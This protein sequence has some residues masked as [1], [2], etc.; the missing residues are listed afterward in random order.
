MTLRTPVPFRV[1]AL[2][3]IAVSVFAAHP[4]RDLRRNAQRPGALA[5]AVQGGRARPAARRSESTLRQRL[6]SLSRRRRERTDRAL[7]GLRMVSRGFR[8]RVGY[9]RAVSPAVRPG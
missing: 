3:L 2:L 7:E 4:P 5:R 1:L 6:A 8:A 9:A